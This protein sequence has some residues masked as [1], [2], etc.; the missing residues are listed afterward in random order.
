MVLKLYNTLTRKKGVFK[1]IDPK[2]V[3][4]YSCGPT[5]YDHAHVGNF[6]AYV[7]VDLLKRYLLYKGLDV[8]HIMNITD[9]EDK[10]IKKSIKQKKPFKQITEF[11]TQEFFDDLEQLRIKK[12]DEYPKATEHIPQ[13]VSII[14]KLLANGHAYKSEDGSVYYNI[15]SFKD[16]GKL[17]HTKIESLKAGARVK[18]DS[19]D[20]ENAQDFALWKA[21]DSSDGDVFWES[22]LGKGRPGWHI[23]CSAMSQCHLGETF[24]IHAGGVDLIFPH[25]ENEIA[26]SEGASGKKFA[27]FWFHNEHLL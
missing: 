25:H 17:S 26:Q 11:Y 9:V 14:Q 23:E 5:V 18:Q 24:D 13:M 6:R 19:Y 7:C 1:P 21:Y 15:A 10:I 27:H 2:M 8:A 20:K 4:F 3:R 16:Y 12:A 22:E